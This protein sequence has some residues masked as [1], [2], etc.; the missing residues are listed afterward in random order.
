MTTVQQLACRGGSNGGLLVGN[1]LARYPDLFGAVWCDVPLL[2]MQ[3]YTK[4]LAGQSWI[5]EYGDPDVASGVA[6]HPPLLAL[7]SGRAR[8]VI[9]RRSSSPPTAP[10]IACIPATRA[11]WR[12]S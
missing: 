10:T 7:S 4:L 12:R 3:R 9:I 5:A 6:L 2:D 1:M 11:R 8:A